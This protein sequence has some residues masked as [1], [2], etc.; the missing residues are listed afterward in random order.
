MACNSAKIVRERLPKTR[1]VV[2]SGH[3]E[4][5]HA[6]QAIKPGVTE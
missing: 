5:D 3:D 4:F 1:L 6:Q 2:L